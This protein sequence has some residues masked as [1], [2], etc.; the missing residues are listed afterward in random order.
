MGVMASHG[1]LIDQDAAVLLVE[2]LGHK[3]DY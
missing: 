3:Y 2:E 1:Q